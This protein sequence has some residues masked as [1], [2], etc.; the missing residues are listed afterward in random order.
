ME[1]RFVNCP[2]IL[3]AYELS[4]VQD[5]ATTAMTAVELKDSE[6]DARG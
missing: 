2:C 5:L 6:F 3:F 1:D 4:L